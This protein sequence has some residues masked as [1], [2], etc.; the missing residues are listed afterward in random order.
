MKT[1]EFVKWPSF[2]LK[3]GSVAFELPLTEE[4]GSCWGCR[5]QWLSSAKLSSVRNHTGWLSIKRWGAGNDE[6]PTLHLMMQLFFEFCVKDT[7]RGFA[8]LQHEPLCPSGFLCLWLSA[9]WSS[10]ATPETTCRAQLLWYHWSPCPLSSLFLMAE[11]LLLLLSLL[12]H[13]DSQFWGP[14]LTLSR[15]PSL[16]EILE[17]PLTPP[18]GHSN[19]GI[20]E[21]KERELPADPSGSCSQPAQSAQSCLSNRERVSNSNRRAGSHW[22]V[23]WA[24]G[25]ELLLWHWHCL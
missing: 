8:F 7:N 10:L 20:P 6:T 16:K 22:Q 11:K 14:P 3:F 17:L 18:P 12:L 1:C 25:W 19:P 4:A 5:W 23:P 15:S 2:L 21:T 13:W 9:L 24:V